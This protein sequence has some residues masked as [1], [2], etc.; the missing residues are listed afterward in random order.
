MDRLS[1][2]CR[3]RVR[4]SRIPTIGAAILIMIGVAADSSFAES[5]RTDPAKD[6][7]SWT[8]TWRLDSELSDSTAELLKSLEVPWPMRKIA[9]VFTPTLVIHDLEGSLEISSRSPMGARVNRIWGD[10]QLRDGED[11]MGRP[12]K[13]SSRWTGDAELTIDRSVE[14]KSGRIATLRILWTVDATTLMSTTLAVV[15]NQPEIS[16]RRVFKRVR[17]EDS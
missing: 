17:A 14:L 15:P 9:A 4:S 2:A 11:I 3:S 16:V 7:S 5:H 12:F 1:M 10:Q 8:D 6:L 13:E